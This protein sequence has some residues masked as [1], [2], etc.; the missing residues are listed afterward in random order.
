MMAHRVLLGLVVGIL[1]LI[2]GCGDSS[3]ESKAAPTAE[4]VD[5]ALPSGFVACPEPRGDMCTADYDPVCGWRTVVDS[6]GEYE[7][8]TFSNGC[9]AC[10]DAAVSGFVAGTCEANQE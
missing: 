9:T 10:T 2:A 1:A 6:P 5:A 4:Q 3:S 8:Q 7:R